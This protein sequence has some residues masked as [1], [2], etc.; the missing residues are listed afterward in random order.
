[1]VFLLMQTSV[2][3]GIARTEAIAI[4]WRESTVEH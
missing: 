2:G 1:M 4:F 3:A